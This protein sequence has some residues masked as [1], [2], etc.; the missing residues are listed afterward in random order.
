[1]KC[2]GCIQAAKS[3]KK[4]QGPFFA[5]NCQVTF[6]PI[7]VGFYTKDAFQIHI[8]SG[9]YRNQCIQFRNARLG[10]EKKRSMQILD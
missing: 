9:I 6:G 1:M 2:E 8:L 5:P 10:R 7:W 3:S 4:R